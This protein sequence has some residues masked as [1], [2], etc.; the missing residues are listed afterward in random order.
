MNEIWRD[1]KGFEAYYSVSNLGRLKSHERVV[2]K[3][4]GVNYTVREK[5]I[6]GVLSKSIGYIVV[7]LRRGDKCLKTTL[8]SLVA[9]AFVPNPKRKPQVNHIDGNKIN[10]IANNLEWSTGMENTKHAIRLGLFNNK[11][12]KNGMSKLNKNQV[13]EI[14]K[15][16][17]TGNVTHNKLS[18]EYGVS[19]ST[20]GEITRR[21]IW[22]HI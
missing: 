11:G 22:K 19:V 1:V 15:R 4:N 6:S 17:D 21:E 13:L 3:S 9:R 10:N 5:I 8:H 2:Q 14:R 20:I 7:T 12:N 16:Y 18:R